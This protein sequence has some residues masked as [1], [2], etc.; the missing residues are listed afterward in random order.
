VTLPLIDPAD[1]TEAQRA[2]LAEWSADRG[3]TRTPANLWRMLVASPE[4]MRAVGKL[5]A[6][7]RVGLTIDL[8]PKTVVA[9]VA[10]RQRG[11]GHEIG[12]Q[13]ARLADAGIDPADVHAAAQGEVSALPAEL[14]AAARL[15]GAMA[16][17]ARPRADDVAT[18]RGLLGDTGFVQLLVS[19]AYFLMLGD[20]AGVL[21]PPAE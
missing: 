13:E 5:G 7:V 16:S 20:I 4:S 15:A 10:S 2:A 18:L 9:A 6:H 12:I 8:L 1:A 11:Y 19:A 14:A 3:L 17:G 21:Q